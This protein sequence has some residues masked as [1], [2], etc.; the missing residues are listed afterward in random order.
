MLRTGIYQI[1]QLLHSSPTDCYGLA[2]PISIAL[3]DKIH[4]EDSAEELGERILFQFSNGRA[5]FKRTHSRRFEEFD[6]QVSQILCGSFAASD[7][8]RVHDLG[9]SDGRTACDF[10]EKLSPLFQQLEY[11]ASDYESEV[12]VFESNNK[13]LALSVDGQPLEMV[14]PPFVF[15][16]VQSPSW[17]RY[18][19]HR[20]CQWYYKKTAL[21]RLQQ[22]AQVQPEQNRRVQL[23]SQRSLKLAAAHPNFHLLTYNVLQP[24]RVCHELQAVRAMNVLNPNYF[25]PA[26]R[27]LALVNIHA[28]LKDG[29][30]LISGS[31]YDASSLVNGGVYRKQG[32]GFELHTKFG[33]GHPWHQE[34]LTLN[35]G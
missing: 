6:E 2:R 22:L 9:I 30:V 8:F 23:F 19:L 24:F 3:Y 14:V 15:N 34:I 25:Q 27:H 32:T 10:Y 35:V 18:P 33:S 11:W 1:E 12:N 4:Q 21:P 16:L 17:K 31:N 5:T 29:G 28:S 13:S 7:P 26:E 20:L